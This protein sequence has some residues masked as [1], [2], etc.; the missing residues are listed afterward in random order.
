[1]D[2]CVHVD[3]IIVRGSVRY[4]GRKLK[5]I[6]LMMLLQAAMIIKSLPKHCPAFN[7]DAL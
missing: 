5:L 4:I 2:G 7:F 3:G 6:N 1:M